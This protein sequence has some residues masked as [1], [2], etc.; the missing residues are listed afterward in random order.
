MRVLLS[1]VDLFCFQRVVHSRHSFVSRIMLPCSTPSVGLTDASRSSSPPH[2]CPFHPMSPLQPFVSGGPTSSK[3]P[4]CACHKSATWPRSDPLLVDLTH[5]V[6]RLPPTP[7]QAAT[8]VPPPSIPG[9][10]ELPADDAE[11][12]APGTP[13]QHLARHRAALR[14][15]RWFS[16]VLA[17]LG[18]LLASRSAAPAASGD[19]ELNPNPRTATEWLV[20]WAGSDHVE[21][22]WEPEALL[23]AG[24]G[25][26]AEL[27]GVGEFGVGAFEAAL[28]RYRHFS[29]GAAATASP[30]CLRPYLGLR[31]KLLKRV[32][33]EEE[34][35]RMKQQS[36]KPEPG[37]EGDRGMRARTSRR[38]DG[39]TGGA[40]TVALEDE[41]VEMGVS[42][43]SSSSS[44]ES[45][46]SS[47]SATS[48][49]SSSSSPSSTSSSSST[50]IKQPLSSTS[51]AAP[52]R[53]P[54]LDPRDDPSHGLIPG[55][56]LRIRSV[57]GWTL[58]DYQQEGVTWLCFNHNKG[59]NC[60][61]GRFPWM[62]VCVCVSVLNLYGCRLP[63]FSLWL[64]SLKL[65]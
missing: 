51:S 15:G 33:A 1:L 38:N 22:T 62:C 14:S 60:L 53:C 24:L 54:I 59:R 52:P 64:S 32:A 35:Q 19:A 57:E 26:C 17:T 7:R 39:E 3:R 16:P 25:A 42:T 41:D 34:E 56:N 11:H 44:A 20:K 23:R 9:G 50:A 5:L 18:R 43:S 46:S 55:L 2:L 40:E 21:S 31:R 63:L 4:P 6:P 45:S 36:E 49:S 28:A 65:A 47:S 8:A 13:G 10:S 12:L 30:D 27:P 48:S 58:R 61:L 37:A 29:R